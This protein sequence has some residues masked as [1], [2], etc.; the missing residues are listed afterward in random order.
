MNPNNIHIICIKDVILNKWRQISL[1][2]LDSK[3]HTQFE[4][5]IIVPNLS[6]YV[7]NL[8]TYVYIL[9]IYMSIE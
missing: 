9:N 4:E 5:K 7:P 6:T 8:S 3:F 2:Y 1:C